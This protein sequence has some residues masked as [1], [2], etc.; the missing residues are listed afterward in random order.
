[1][2]L[3][4]G[5]YLAAMLCVLSFAVATAWKVGTG[6]VPENRLW[7]RAWLIFVSMVFVV[8]PSPWLAPIGAI[9][10]IVRYGKV[11]RGARGAGQRTASD[12]GDVDLRPR[13]GLR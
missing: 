7:T 12:I 9:Y 2:S 10:V 6:V 3:P 11:W 5:L 8:G 13:R 1:M 4:H